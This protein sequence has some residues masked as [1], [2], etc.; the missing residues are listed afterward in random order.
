MA[1]VTELVT[2][3]K[4][5]GSTSPLNQY[6][7]S[8][9][10][11]IG[12]LSGMTVALAAAGAAVSKW[13]SGVL[14]AF[15][16]TEQLSRQTGVAVEWIQEMGFAASVNGGNVQGLASTVDSLSQKIGEA[17]QK[18]SEDFARLGISVRDANGHV[19]TADVVLGDVGARFRSLG[20]SMSEQRSFAS[21]L[22]IDASL[23]QTLNLTSAQLA[24]LR[25]EARGLGILTG[26]QAD[27]AIKYNDSLTRLRFGFDGLQRILAV[28][29][30]PQM[31]ETAKWFTE[32][33][34][35]NR[36][37]IIDGVKYGMDILSD[38]MDM[39]GRIMP[40]LSLAAG[41]FLVFKVATLGLTGAL[42]A[43]FSPAVLIAA[44]IAAIILVVDD[45]IVAFQ[46]GESAI[47]DFFMSFFGFDITPVLQDL[48][49]AFKNVMIKLLDIGKDFVAALGGLFSGLGKLLTGNFLGAFEDV[50]AAL[51]IMAGG[52]G[53]IFS[54]I[55]GGFF[56]GE[57]G[58][59]FSDK[60][61]QPG[62]AGLLS[63]GGS[64]S[65]IEQTVNMEIRTSDPERAGRAA[66]ENLQRQLDDAQTQ[67][68]RGGR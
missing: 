16:S 8:L 27:Q 42:A 62:G 38:F 61:F 28:G 32:L 48:V 25:E 46:G 24:D 52:F 53:K 7:A 21:A 66:A 22:G 43:L 45:L 68:S 34:K 13:A 58:P 4:F 14:Q 6:N 10:K 37:W 40:V 51:N 47:R 5:S 39:L 26:E 31:E 57:D 63:S 18:G 60:S 44:G 1:T 19:K 55:F 50:N 30:A 9:G 2:E 65:R 49:T 35:N 15:D 56:E 64:S 3:F 54:G 12:L 59:T 23:I 33:L 67:A 11:G 41:T 20:L 36:D 29:L 17:A